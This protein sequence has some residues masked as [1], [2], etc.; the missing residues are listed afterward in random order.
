MAASAINPLRYLV[1]SPARRHYEDRGYC[2][3]RN[4]FP[5]E[6]IRTIA[7]LSINL[8]PSYEGELRRLDGRFAA[9][10]FFPG[11]RLIRNSVLQAHESLPIQLGAIREALC[12]LIT[13]PALG[14]RLR[15]L[16]GARHYAIHQ[17]LLFFAAQMT[18]LHLDSWA[19]DTAPRGYAHTAWIPLQD[20]D[21]RSGVPSVIPWPKGKVVTEAELGIPETG[22]RV[23]RYA[24]YH[25]ALRD[26][27]LRKSPEA[28]APLLRMG[29]FI[30][31]SSLTPHFTLPSYPFPAERLSLQ[32]LLRP[33]DTRWGDFLSQPYHRTS[34]PLERIT[35]HFSILRR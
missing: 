11:T 22:S 33:A 15:Q 13:L 20:L 14:E 6:H 30:V 25:Q 16:D 28:V 7:E 8:L 4:A 29:D 3:F 1:N 12:S 24:R 10:D 27:V 5:V 21:Y 34:V 35:E 23:E 18:D 26:S 17:S 9:N 32:V 31:W 19:V 2:I